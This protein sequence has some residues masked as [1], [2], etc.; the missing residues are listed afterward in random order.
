MSGQSGSPGS[1]AWDGEGV[2]DVPAST[3]VRDPGWGRCVG[4]VGTCLLVGVVLAVTVAVT[5]AEGS[6]NTRLMEMRESVFPLIC[7]CAGGAAIIGLALFFPSRYTL[8]DDQLTRV[9]V[10][11]ARSTT[12]VAGITGIKWT[13]SA[14]VKG[15]HI[16]SYNLNCTMAF[17]D[18]TRPLLIAL[19]ESLTRQNLVDFTVHGSG[20]R[21]A[22]GLP[23]TAIAGRPRSASGQRGTASVQDGSRLGRDAERRTGVVAPRSAPLL[24]PF[25]I[26]DRNRIESGVYIF[27]GLL[28]P[29]VTWFLLRDAETA[30]WV[31][32]LF[33]SA[34][35]FG[36]GVILAS[37]LRYRRSLLVD[38]IGVVV[39]NTLRRHRI[40]WSEIDGIDVVKWG[41]SEGGTPESSR[42]RFDRGPGRRRVMSHV[43]TFPIGKKKELKVLAAQLLLLKEQ[44]TSQSTSPIEDTKPSSTAGDAGGVAPPSARTADIHPQDRR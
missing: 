17:R 44:Q 30:V 22:L 41:Q 21:R 24:L 16:A 33:V 29:L 26:Q 39:S 6:F 36:L 32:A 7:L 10:W 38:E 15:V 9:R 37:V 1:G 5:I 23:R 14:L 19:G 31:A 25:R 28:V 34:W 18:E 2:S 12:R 20:A 43:P 8:Q 4:G 3:T 35:I 42:L 11:G 27:C 13:G 40:S